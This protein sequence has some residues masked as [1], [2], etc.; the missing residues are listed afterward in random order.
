MII[1]AILE[2]DFNEIEKR[3]ALVEGLSKEVQIDV[4]D[5]TL[6]KE[7]TFLDLPKLNQLNTTADISVHL[8]VEKPADFVEKYEKSCLDMSIK[9][10]L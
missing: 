9:R 7:E 8:M 2:K 4:L 10:R 5:N 1:P 6:I 3:V